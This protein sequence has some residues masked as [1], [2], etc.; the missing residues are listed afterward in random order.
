[1]TELILM[2]HA[3]LYMFCENHTVGHSNKCSSIQAVRAS[4][5]HILNG[6]TLTGL[7]FNLSVGPSFCVRELYYTA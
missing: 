5:F 1:M 6:N 3:K 7:Q 2:K 4:T